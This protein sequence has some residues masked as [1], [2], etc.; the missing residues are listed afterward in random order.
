M[1]PEQNMRG[2]T[3]GGRKERSVWEVLRQEGAKVGTVHKKEYLL[4]K[5]MFLDYLN[6]KSWFM[7][8]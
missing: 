8:V 1:R 4:I 3:G 5:V 6:N 2:R 7:L